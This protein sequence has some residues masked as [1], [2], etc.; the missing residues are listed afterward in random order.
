MDNVNGTL[1]FYSIIGTGCSDTESDR[2]DIDHLPETCLFE[3]MQAREWIFRLS[4]GPEEAHQ[5]CEVIISMAQ[6][7]WA[8]RYG[9]AADTIIGL[10]REQWINWTAHLY[11]D[12]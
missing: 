2:S 7:A 8:T 11:P 6:S 5:A 9:T 4:D 12:A 10:R 1:R 3:E